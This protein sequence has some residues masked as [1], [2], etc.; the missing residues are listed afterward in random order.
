MIARR[1]WIA[2]DG[3]RAVSRPCDLGGVARS[4]VYGASAGAALDALD[5]RL[6]API[7][8]RYT[9][10]PFYGSRRMAVYLKEQGHTVNR[11][12]VQRPMR[13]LGLAGMAPGPNASRSHPEHRIYP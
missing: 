3:E 7:D 8:A 12:R 13:V 5:L 1:T 4:W 6:L 10:R 11:K 9:R 2:R